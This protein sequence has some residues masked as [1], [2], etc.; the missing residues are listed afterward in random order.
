MDDRVSRVRFLA[1]AGNFSLHH[2]FQNGSGAHP[3]SYPMSTRDYFPGDKA[4]GAWSWPFTSMLCRGQRMRGAIPPLLQYA[5][6]AW[7]FQLVNSEVTVVPIEISI[8]ST[9]LYHDTIPLSLFCTVISFGYLFSVSFS[10]GYPEPVVNISF[11]IHSYQLQLDHF[12]LVYYLHCN[13]SVDIRLIFVLNVLIHI[14]TLNVFLTKFIILI[15]HLILYN[16]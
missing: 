5:F 12:P 2:R 10:S 16:Y 11:Q 15:L 9:R 6:M 4:A 8:P 14:W 7:C 1:G 13:A 3:A